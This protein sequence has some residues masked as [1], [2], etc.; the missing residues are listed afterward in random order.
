MATAAPALGGPVSDWN[1]FAAARVGGRNLAMTQIAVH[2]ALNSIDSRYETYTD[3]A[4]A[5]DGA[6]PD[7]AV[8]AASQVVL[9][10]VVP[11]AQG[12]AFTTTTT[13]N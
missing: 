9:L 11:P 4:P 12:T 5:A 10:A 2:D 1:A 8:A 3:V 7:A 13:P 6:L